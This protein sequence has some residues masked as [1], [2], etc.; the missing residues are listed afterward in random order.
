M[1]T[2]SS[3]RSATARSRF[4]SSRDGRGAAGTPRSLTAPFVRL[5]RLGTTGALMTAG[6]ALGAGALPVP[7]PLFGLRVLGLPGR[8]V[9]VALALAYA[10]AGLVVL[11]WLG[12][13]RLLLRPGGPVVPRAQLV[14]TAV[15]W[16][17]P[18]AVAPPLFS[19]DVYSYLAQGVMAAR[20][21]DPYVLGPAAALGVDHPLVRS[22]PTMWRD[23]PTPYGPL[24]V[25][26]E[27]GVAAVVGD[28]IVLGLLAHRVLALAGAA[29][30][31]WALPRLAARCHVDGS[32]ALWLGA[33]NPL[34]LFHVVSGV[35]NDGLMIGLACAG[36][37]LG[38]AAGPRLADP[39]LLGGAA[40]VVC[41]AAVKIPALLVLGFLGVACARS[42]GGGARAVATVAAVLATVAAVVLAV[43][44]WP[45]P[46]GWGWVATLTV[47]GASVAWMSL[48]TDLGLLGGFL[49]TA[50]GLGDHTA[51]VL[52]LTR[53]AGL[54]AAVGVCVALLVATL[55]GRLDPVRG[56]AAAAA[57]VVLLAPVVQPWYL[58]WVAVPLAAT[59]VSVRWTA[60]AGATAI[61]AVPSG[62]DFFF[63]SYQLPLVITGACAVFAACL[64]MPEVRPRPRPAL[65]P[66][67]TPAPGRRPVAS[68][69]GG[70]VPLHDDEQR[71]DERMARGQAG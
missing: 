33:A 21:L 20:G 13:A 10:G 71:D 31:V 43:L 63:R 5:R 8:N 2:S 65:D 52:T 36:L 56:V 17:L 11:A 7:N 55:R 61:L 1:R 59:R 60:A 58:L 48:S 54:V 22:I 69:P 42:R 19:R 9:T 49:G 28:D 4:S 53:A 37:E 50:G 41:G 16:A 24:F 25:L 32:T 38:L 39:R 14:R 47:P 67:S 3:G 6:A 46:D 29:A 68:R 44:A 26:L 66:A 57:A 27:R 12:V 35:H 45:L 64:L 62:A 18:L 51:T 30:I 34:V 70:R 15:T 23:T 40:M